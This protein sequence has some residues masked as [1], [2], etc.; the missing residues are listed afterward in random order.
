MYET[1]HSQLTE[2]GILQRA[3]RAL[4]RAMRG[5]KLQGEDKRSHEDVK[6][7]RKNRSAG[8][9][10]KCPLVWTCVEKG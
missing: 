6:N 1:L 4:E 3:E 2:I 9:S 7:G 5:M 10:E 8:K